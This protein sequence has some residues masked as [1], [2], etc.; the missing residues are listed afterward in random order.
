MT[1][2]NCGLE[3]KN[4]GKFCSNCG[5]SVLD[6]NDGK[7]L[8][9]ASPLNTPRRFNYSKKFFAI[10]GLIAVIVAVSVYAALNRKVELLVEVTVEAPFGAVFKS[11]NGCDPL[12]E[13][14]WL[15]NG[16]KKQ[17]PLTLVSKSSDAKVI[18]VPVEWV[19]IGEN[20]CKSS[21]F[22]N[23]KKNASWAVSL[24]NEELTTIGDINWRTGSVEVDKTIKVTRNL[25]GALNL[26]QYAD[27]CEGTLIDWRCSWGSYNRFS[28]DLNEETGQCMGT[29]G[30]SDIKEGMIVTVFGSDGSTVGTGSITSSSYRLFDFDNFEIICS[31]FWEIGEVPN[32]DK[33]YSVEIGKRGKV[34]FDSQTLEFEGWN[35]QTY[36]GN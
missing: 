14:R 19:N 16:P 36:I 34:F 7:N 13:Y 24:N 28:L 6:Q 30:Y 8:K 33:G 23:V 27:F 17:S 32:D 1:C 20:T 3:I 4:L 29:E 9:E 22:V 31:L 18:E 12:Q 25:S 2:I 35:L 5:T 15:V 10:L 26:S 11:E 21:T